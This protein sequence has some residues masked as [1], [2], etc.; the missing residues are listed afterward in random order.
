MPPGSRTLRFK[1]AFWFVA[2]FFVI[3][4]LMIGGVKMFRRGEVRRTVEGELQLHAQDLIENILSSEIGWDAVGIEPLIPSGSNI[5]L[6]A[7]RD[8]QG[9]LLTTWNAADPKL[10]PFAAL[11]LIPAGTLSGVHGVV[12]A[13]KAEKLTGEPGV[14]RLVTLPFRQDGKEYIFQAAVRDEVTLAT[15]LGPYR[16]LVSIGV[17]VGILAAAIAAWIIAGRALSPLARMSEVARDVSP[18]N[19]QERFQ[20]G[21]TDNEIARLEAELNSAM[22]RIEAGYRAQD[23]FLSNAS[24]ELKTPLA[25]LLTQAQVAKMGEP[26]VEKGYAFIDRAESLIARMSKLVES[27]LV[28][29][30]AEIR[31]RP[32]QEAVAIVDVV[33]G[34]L[35]TCQLLAQQGSVSLSPQLT[36]SEEED[37]LTIPGDA[38]LLQ[39]MLEN[40]V[41]NAISH[42]PRGSQVVIDVED[43]EDE[44]T[45]AV[46]D[47]GP[48]V[49]AEY[50]EKIFDRF[51]R[52]PDKQVRR[53]GS[54]LGLA[55]AHRITQLHQGRIY[56]ENNEGAGCTFHVALPKSRSAPEESSS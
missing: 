21:L 40:L 15:L 44:V 55:I 10:I 33:L 13:D 1:L 37:A 3:Q 14:L 32:P 11:H 39:T 23:Q 29:A 25:V 7:I 19:L 17:P 51:S 56:A 9:T 53:D 30:R 8:D 35:Q 2:I 26:S 46:R 54:G 18:T 22:E 41:R 38:N 50:L 43:T 49:P 48:G 47:E 52:V 16:E 6:F 31:T 34:C 36:D 42:S 24:H 28:L 45:I 12:P 20:V 4:S 5:V 27:L